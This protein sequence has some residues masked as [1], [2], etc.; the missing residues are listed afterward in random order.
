M[1]KKLIHG[2]LAMLILCGSVPAQAGIEIAE[3][4]LVDLRSEDL[5]PGPVAEW[6][7][8]GSLGGSFMA[9]GNP[10]VEDIGDWANAVSF[11]GQSF[12][13]GPMSTPGIEG[14]G[15]RSIEV[16]AY[17]VGITDEQ[18]MVSW[19]HR[20]G[21]DATNMAFNYGQHGTWGAVGHWGAPDMG[22]EGDHAPH[23][24]LETWWHLAY[25]YD[26]TTSRLYVNGDPAGEDNLTLNTYGGEIIRV[27]SQGDDANADGDARFHFVGAISQ[28]RIHD[29]AL[30]AE[31]VAKNAQIR[32][33]SFGKASNPAP[34]DQAVDVLRDSILSWSPG[35]TAHTHDVYLGTVMDDVAAG[36]PSVLVSAGQQATT[37]DPGLLDFGQTYFWRVDEINAP[38]DSSAI[39]GEV[40]SFTVEPYSYPVDSGITVTASGSFAPNTGPEK[41]I[42]GSGLNELDQHSVDGSDMWTSGAGVTWIQYEFD[43]VHKLDQMWVW[44]SNQI[45]EAFMGLGAKDVTIETSADGAEWTVLEEATLF[46]Q[47]TGSPDYTA[48]TTI[49]FGGVLAKFVKIT[50][51]SGYGLMPQYS[52]SELRFFSIPVQAREPMPASGDVV[53]DVDVVLQWR[54]GREA[55]VH[56]VYLGTDAMDL[57]LLGSTEAANYD[58]SAAGIEY[59]K[60]YYWQINEVNEA[61]TPSSYPGE[62]WSFTTPDY[63]AV[64]DFEVYDDNCNRI[65]FAWQDGWGHN[66]G[67]NIDD[68]DVPPYNGNG[69]GSLVG[70]DQAPFAERTIVHSG[71]QS[72]P[73][74]YDGAGSEAQREFAVPQDWTKGGAQS[75]A[76]SFAGSPSDNA[77]GDV[78]VT[79]NGVKK[80]VSTSATALQ[81]PVWSLGTVDLASVGTNL[82]SVR[83]LAVGVD[84]SGTGTVYVD[85]IRLYR[86]AP[87]QAV[88]VDPGTGDLMA[89][90]AME[91]NLQDSTGSGYDGTAPE[92]AASY[93]DGPVGLGSALSL[94]AD[95]FA[96]QYVELPIGPLVTTLTSATFA[97]WVDYVSEGNNWVRVFDFGTSNTE[98]YM[99]LC[100]STGTNGP[101]RLAITQAA[102]GADESLID[103][104]MTLPAGWHHVAA[105]FDA[106][107]MTMQ[108]YLDG[109]VVAQGATATLPADMGSTTQNWLGRSQ[110]DADGL[111]TGGIDE[112]RIYNRALSQAEILYLAGAR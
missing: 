25:T 72:M 22:W 5:A 57:A 86:E 111:F 87:A 65:F 45:I 54:A 56:E 61:A 85:D 96:Q 63:L 13:D 90:Y 78:Y 28:V 7:N 17:K 52:L 24:E 26:G 106:A 11:D 23:P 66:G 8:H 1:I 3:E 35:D 41:T 79:I 94:A 12:F 59:G 46:N 6:P 62:I 103:A 49:D 100:P 110:Y 34:P 74:G 112:F 39:A 104:P 18:T 14:D 84:S 68:C 80:L 50:I 31:Q 67:E 40:W 58:L 16:W 33:Q 101:M 102:G 32:I 82:A 4:L 89:H 19:A 93:T 42:D 99:F 108:L 20:G 30:T 47:A 81:S 88:P 27:A 60:T 69:T 44:N 9:S 83:N 77:A 51:H 109:Q 76:V 98:G 29:G 107:S 73:M 43:Q 53:E 21:P 2:L 55:A 15:T 97:T 71:R 37:Y 92:L 38:P 105:V 36:D 64:D 95:D 91:N 70:N 48:N 75:L 10:M